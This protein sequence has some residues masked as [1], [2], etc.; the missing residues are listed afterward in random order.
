M[1]RI[2]GNNIVASESEKL[3][4]NT[5]TGC[6]QRFL[7][8]QCVLFVGVHFFLHL[9]QP[10]LAILSDFAGQLGQITSVFDHFLFISVAL[11]TTHS[12]LCSTMKFDHWKESKNPFKVD[13]LLGRLK[14]KNL[15]K[16]TKKIFI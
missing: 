15:S 8:Y 6:S 10:I 1:H 7:Y 16:S 4:F 3:F 9:E 11:I 13:L 5:N 14:L 2:T 12:I